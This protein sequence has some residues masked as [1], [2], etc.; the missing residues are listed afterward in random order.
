MGSYRG[1]LCFFYSEEEQHRG[2]KLVRREEW[3]SEVERLKE[4][5][6]QVG[7]VNEEPDYRIYDYEQWGEW[8]DDLTQQWEEGRN[9]EEGL[10][11][12]KKQLVSFSIYRL[13]YFPI[14][15]PHSLLTAKLRR[16]NLHSGLYCY[17]LLEAKNR[18]VWMKLTNKEGE[19]YRLK[20]VGNF[21]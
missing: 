9:L 17:T 20:Q 3:R 13:C 2:Y 21:L 4:D 11:E 1:G 8:L 15:L 16:S 5:M 19:D 12:F 14:R 6:A 18:N 7:L 10:H